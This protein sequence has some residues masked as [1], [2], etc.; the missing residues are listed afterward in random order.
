ML[1][2]LARCRSVGSSFVL[3]SISVLKTVSLFCILGPTICSSSSNLATD[4]LMQF[5]FAVCSSRLVLLKAL[6]ITISLRLFVLF[7][8]RTDRFLR[9]RFA[10]NEIEIP[11]FKTSTTT[12]CAP[13]RTEALGVIFNLNCPVRLDSTTVH[14]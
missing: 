8:V 2:P 14:M 12:H 5:L 1:S 7:L 13:A 3:A 6:P 4:I 9:L 10:E 11:Q